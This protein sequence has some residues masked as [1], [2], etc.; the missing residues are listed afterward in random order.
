M[1]SFERFYQ[2]RFHYP[3]KA[4][5]GRLAFENKLNFQREYARLVDTGVPHDRAIVDAAKKISYGRHRIEAG[6]SRLVVETNP[7]VDVDLGPGLG[8][9]KAPTDIRITAEKP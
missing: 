7:P 4:W 1:D 6:F 2:G 9:R 3:L 5:G 8:V